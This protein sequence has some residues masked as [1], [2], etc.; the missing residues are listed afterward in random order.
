MSFFLC[1]TVHIAATASHRL[2]LN[3]SEANPHGIFS[4]DAPYTPGNRGLWCKV[5]YFNPAEFV[6]VARTDPEGTA[7][8]S[9][10]GPRLVLTLQAVR[11]AATRF[12]RR[13]SSAPRAASHSSAGCRQT[14]L[15]RDLG[16]ADALPFSDESF[17]YVLSW[18]VIHHGT[19][20]DVGRRL[21]E[22]WRVLKPGGPF[23]GTVLSTRDANYGLG[24]AIAPDTF[25]IEA[26]DG[27]IRV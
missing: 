15:G 5:K 11:W 10:A 9:H 1:Q 18:N 21:G 27:S 8:L 6:V 13:S 25:V 7:A 20:G 19:L 16:T 17:D 4:I 22:I 3:S 14:Q 24:R 26:A 2:R 23:H 12:S